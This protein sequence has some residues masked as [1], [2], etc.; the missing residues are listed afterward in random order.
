MHCFSKECIGPFPVSNNS[1]NNVN[2]ARKSREKL[3]SGSI[4]LLIII[5]I[6]AFNEK[7][8]IRTLSLLADIM[9]Q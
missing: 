1:G 6:N 8:D 7:P 2:L 3:R 5:I 4:V 9:I